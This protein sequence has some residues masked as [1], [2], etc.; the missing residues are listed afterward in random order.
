L[1]REAATTRVQ[2]P[3]PPALRAWGRGG[4]RPQGAGAAP[5]LPA[6]APPTCIGRR[7]PRE[8][9]Q[10]HHPPRQFDS[11][12]R[13]Q[14]VAPLGPQ[15]SWTA[16]GHRGARPVAP[17]PTTGG[18]RGARDGGLKL[19]AS[20]RPRRDSAEPAPVLPRAGSSAAHR[21]GEWPWSLRHPR[22]RRYGRA[23]AGACR[24]GRSSLD[25]VIGVTRFFTQTTNAK[26]NG[27][28]HAFLLF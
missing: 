19:A 4:P 14:A 22:P 25:N 1:H 2:W 18:R 8:A 16:L 24:R 11:V 21:A 28:F 15:L 7:A 27:S 9:R 3:L 13:E 26:S 17:W 6:V 10:G 12:A 20:G 23:R 5:G